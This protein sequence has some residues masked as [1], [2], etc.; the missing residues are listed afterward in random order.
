MLY[1]TT[2]LLPQTQRAE[3]HCAINGDLG[4]NG[5]EMLDQ[6][7]FD[8]NKA[9]SYDPDNAQIHLLLGRAQC[10]SEDYDLAIHSLLKYEELKPENPIGYLELAFVYQQVCLGRP[11]RYGI[12]RTEAEDKKLGTFC[13]NGE[14][15]G[16]VRNALRATGTSE[17]INTG[18]IRELFT[19]NDF[20]GVSLAYFYNS[21]SDEEFFG[22]LSYQDKF[23]WTVSAIHSSQFIPEVFFSDIPIHVLEE[24]ITIEAEDLHWLLSNPEWDVNIGDLLS[25]FN[26]TQTGMGV[27]FWNGRAVAPIKVSETGLYKISIYGKNTFPGPVQMSLVIDSNIIGEFELAKEDDS[28][29]EIDFVTSLRSGVHLIGLQFMNN[30]ID[31]NIDRDAIIDLIRIEQIR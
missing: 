9:F 8:L 13:S 7:I 4:T 14:V 5:Q 18:D 6:S 15:I 23:I 30:G 17:D 21:I 28:L 31:R 2:R 16:R 26:T 1:K 11:N 12:Q 10:L 3:F 27:F 20:S 22:E 24:H 29:Q 25:K 19:L